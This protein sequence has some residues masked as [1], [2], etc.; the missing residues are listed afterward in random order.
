MTK[1]LLH[2]KT[3][4]KIVITGSDP[5]KIN[6]ILEN[7]ISKDNLPEKYGGSVKLQYPV[8]E[9]PFFLQIHCRN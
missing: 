9:L 4:N 6:E 5:K 2:E 8:S 3:Q 1:P 7:H